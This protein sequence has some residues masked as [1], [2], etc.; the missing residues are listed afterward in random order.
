VKKPIL[1]RPI[2]SRTNGVINV[3]TENRLDAEEIFHWSLVGNQ[4]TVASLQSG[5]KSDR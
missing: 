2:S 4:W 5:G 1:I 3:M